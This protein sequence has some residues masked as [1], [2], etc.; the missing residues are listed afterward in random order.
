MYEST[1]CCSRV[2]LLAAIDMLRYQ[3][4]L[5]NQCPVEMRRYIVISLEPLTKSKANQRSLT[6]EAE[7][8]PVIPRRLAF[9]TRGVILRLPTI[10][11][12]NSGESDDEMVLWRRTSTARHD[13]GWTW[14]YSL[15]SQS[16]LRWCEGLTVSCRGV[17][18]SINQYYLTCVSDPWQSHKLG[19]SEWPH[20]GSSLRA[21]HSSPAQLVTHDSGNY[22]VRS[23]VISWTPRLEPPSWQAGQ[24]ETPPADT[25]RRVHHSTAT[26]QLIRPSRLRSL[27]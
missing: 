16:R 15:Y 9:F 6:L 24:M 5:G 21:D 10:Y 11:T 1:R 22:T 14:R 27:I 25:V 23:T 3:S 12:K 19:G 8:R 2:G 17:E 13:P 4:E 7:S 26:Y 18:E 20:K